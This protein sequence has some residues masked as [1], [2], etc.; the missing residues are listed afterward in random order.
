MIARIREASRPGAGVGALFGVVDGLLAGLELAG[1]WE[2]GLLDALLATSTAVVLY[3]LLYGLAAAILATLGL[4][5]ARVVG[6]LLGLGLFLELYWRS[7][8]FVFAGYPALSPQRVGT[9]C[10]LAAIAWYCAASCAR[11]RWEP[12]RGLR[13]AA[14]VVVGLTAATG[15]AAWVLDRT[16]DEGRGR[17]HAGNRELPNIVLVIVDA[18]RADHLEPYGS[19]R[20]RTPNI[21]GLATSG[22]LFE[23]A[24]AQAPVTWPSFGSILTGKY[25]LRHGLLSMRAGAVMPDNV[26][27]TR[28]LGQARQIDGTRLVPDDYL[29]AAFMTGALTNGSRLLQGFDQT[30]ELLDGNALVDLSSPWSQLR[31]ELLLMRV[32]NKLRQRLDSNLVV[33]TTIDWIDEHQDR[34]FF[35]LVHLYATHTPYDPPADLRAE[36]L[37]PEYDGTLDSFYAHHRQAIVSGELQLEPADEQRIRDLYAASTAEV[38]RQVGRLL[39][40]LRSRGLEEDTLI[41]LT[42]DH[43]E[44]LGEHGLWEHNWMYETNLHVPLILAWPGRLP[45]GRRVEQRVETIDLLPTLCDLLRLEQ[46]SGAGEFE[47]VDG[48]SLLPLLPTGADRAPRPVYALNAFFASVTDGGWK[49]ISPLEQLERGARVTGRLFDLGTDPT[50]QHDL[51][52]S[53]EEGP[54]QQHARLTE[55]LRTWRAG[56][57]IRE[58]EL[59]R[60]SRDHDDRQ[61]L[62]SLGYVD[63]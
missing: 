15:T 26:T 50:E 10:V 33:K 52:G 17:I 42:A 43:G 47:R 38:D 23:R 35:A 41:V 58:A 53:V 62:R 13:L 56:Q 29:S 54:R 31:A 32:F 59:R 20:V 24:Q 4:G 21:A 40:A 25:P 7:R 57:P 22:V 60:S 37:D 11:R 36:Y 39:E 30:S 9:S 28:H 48:R 34:R 44:E 51:A 3:A 27:L 16:G 5:R 6:L 2:Y 14:S 49:L 12:G 19:T 1:R 8:P 45:A 61:L 46:P 63:V 18:L 55:L